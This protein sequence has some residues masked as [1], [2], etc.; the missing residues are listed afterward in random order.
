MALDA[1]HRGRLS[2]SD[3][4]DI[5]RSMRSQAWG[6]DAAADAIADAIESV[7]ESRCEREESRRQARLAY[8]GLTALSRLGAWASA[9]TL[10]QFNAV[11]E[12]VAR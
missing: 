11:M 4:T 12:R 2:A 8:G 7:V 6:D 10:V 1:K 5:A 3:L 9:R